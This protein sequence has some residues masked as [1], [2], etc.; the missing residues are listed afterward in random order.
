[1]GD[2]KPPLHS[3]LYSC[4]SRTGRPCWC[5]VVRRHSLQHEWFPDQRGV[6]YHEPLTWNE[7]LF[8]TSSCFWLHHLHN[9]LQTQTPIVWNFGFSPVS[10]LDLFY[11]QDWWFL[12]ISDVE[13]GPDKT[14]RSERLSVCQQQT[15][16]IRYRWRLIHCLQLRG[17]WFIFRGFSVKKKG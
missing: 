16:Q 10:W 15:P 6:L 14:D 12:L 1:M 4:L 13:A 11:S 8:N 9:K 17:Q 7:Q 3:N 2:L 5:D